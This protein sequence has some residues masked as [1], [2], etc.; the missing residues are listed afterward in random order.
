MAQL[1]SE[2]GLALIF[3]NVLAEQIGAPIPAMPTLIVAGAM[4]FD[5]KLSAAAIITTAFDACTISDCIWFGAGRIYGRRI[6]GLLCRI[7]LSPDSCVRQT[8]NR[9][10]RWGAVSLV[11]TK[12]IPGLSTIA[13]PLAGAMQLQWPRFLLLNSL[14]AVLWIGASVGAGGLLHHQIDKVLSYIG[15]LGGVAIELLAVLLAGYIAYRWHQR[16]RFLEMMRVARIT[17]DE[18][19][20]LMS[21]EPPPVVVDLRSSI[22]REQDQR[23]IPGAIAI[24]LAEVDRKLQIL[25]IDRDIVFYCSCPNEAS[26]AMAARKLISLGYTRVRPLLGGMDGWIGSGRE[27][28]GQRIDITSPALE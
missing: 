22:I 1:I 21:A 2:Y 15:D 8:E 23:R 17:A 6:I 7:S 27:V 3:L 28:D 16:R 25:P 11:F 19:Y 4:A 5:G 9:Y 10:K 14:G 12:F 13:R 20:A 26:A 24:D 18:L